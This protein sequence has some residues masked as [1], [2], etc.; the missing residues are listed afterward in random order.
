MNHA[1]AGTVVDKFNNVFCL[2]MYMS[3]SEIAYNGLLL[4]YRYLATR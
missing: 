4:K 3:G 2:Y 1:C